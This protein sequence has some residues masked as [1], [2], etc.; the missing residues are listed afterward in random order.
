MWDH[1][2]NSPL[3]GDLC[4]EPWP[5]KREWE[6]RGQRNRDKSR[7]DLGRGGDRR[8][9]P[10]EWVR[11]AGTVPEALGAR[12]L[13]AAFSSRGRGWKKVYTKSHWKSTGKQGHCQQGSGPMQK[14]KGLFQMN[15]HMTCDHQMQCA[16]LAWV[17]A[18]T[19]Q[20]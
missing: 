9:D 20:L 18:P 5:P 3:P 6:A 2:L 8:N 12:P 7:R 17:M 4:K 11:G 1:P 13:P 14:G 19:N 15:R 10:G 16:A